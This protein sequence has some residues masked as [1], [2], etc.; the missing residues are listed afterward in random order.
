M[1]GF[2]ESVF[3]CWWDVKNHFATEMRDQGRIAHVPVKVMLQPLLSPLLLVG[4]QGFWSGL[5]R[6]RDA[7]LTYRALLSDFQRGILRSGSYA[8][9]MI[10]K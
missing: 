1:L 8:V 3:T 7:C 10:T 5:E 6:G 4:I 9:N 2:L